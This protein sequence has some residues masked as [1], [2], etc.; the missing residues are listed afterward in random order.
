MFNAEERAKELIK[1]GKSE[2]DIIKILAEETEVDTLFQTATQGLKT[3][4]EQYQG[5]DMASLNVAIDNLAAC[6]KNITELRKILEQSKV[7][8]ETP[9][10]VPQPA[11]APVE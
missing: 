6:G 1:A 4:W 5:D 8:V 7:G 10:A 2:E 11:P 9:G 3:A